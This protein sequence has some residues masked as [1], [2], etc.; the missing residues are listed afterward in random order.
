MV[1]QRRQAGEVSN[2]PPAPAS[3]GLPQTLTPLNAGAISYSYFVSPVY[4]S[5][6]FTSAV[7][8]IPLAEPRENRSCAYH[9]FTKFGEELGEDGPNFAT[10]CGSLVDT[11]EQEDIT[12]SEDKFE[13]IASLDVMTMTPKLKT[14]NAFEVEFRGGVSSAPETLQLNYFGVDGF[15][16]DEND[17]VF[18][19]AFAEGTSGVLTRTSDAQLDSNNKAFY[20]LQDTVTFKTLPEVESVVAA[21]RILTTGGGPNTLSLDGILGFDEEHENEIAGVDFQMTIDQVTLQTD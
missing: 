2:E 16:K 5:I 9:T 8:S 6:V 17:Q 7:I 13:R 14:E 20:D 3:I 4:S 11:E 21:T 12:V 15:I 18:I 19:A 10:H 1:G